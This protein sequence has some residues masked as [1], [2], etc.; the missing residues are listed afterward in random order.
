MIALLHTKY[1]VSVCS[2]NSTVQTDFFTRYCSQYSF[3]LSFISLPRLPSGG[4][5]LPQHI[6]HGE[7]YPHAL[8]LS[9]MEEKPVTNSFHSFTFTF[10]IIN[11]RVHHLILSKRVTI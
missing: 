1:L 10:N 7:P 3:Y 4:I 5:D 2:L 11:E 8:L 9:V 6:G